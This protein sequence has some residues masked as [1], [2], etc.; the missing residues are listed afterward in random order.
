VI[1]L[2]QEFHE[3]TLSRN[4][5]SVMHSDKANRNEVQGESGF[6]RY[7]G[8]ARVFSNPTTIV[9]IRFQ[10]GLAVMIGFILFLGCLWLSHRPN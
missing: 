2:A 10:K 3:K 1:T 5:A 4:I 6:V 8:L 7:D 9:S